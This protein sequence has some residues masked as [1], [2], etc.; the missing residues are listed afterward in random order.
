[1]NQS[2][3]ERFKNRFFSYAEPFA[4]FS[5]EDKWTI[6]E[7][8][9][10]HLIN[11]ALEMENKTLIEFARFRDEYFEKANTMEEFTISNEELIEKFRQ[12]L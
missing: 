11:Q 7:K 6:S 1:M 10:D 5:E 3:I 8:D 9:F 12:N 2:I 4:Y